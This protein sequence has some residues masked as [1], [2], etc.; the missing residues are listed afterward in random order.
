[1]PKEEITHALKIANHVD[2]LVGK[3]TLRRSA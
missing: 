2:Y 3:P 1:M